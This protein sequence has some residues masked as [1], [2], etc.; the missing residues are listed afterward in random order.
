VKQF[1]RHAVAGQ[2]L[3]EASP[4]DSW[5][6]WLCGPA[7]RTTAARNVSRGTIGRDGR[8]GWPGTARSRAG[9][10]RGTAN[11]AVW[12]GTKDHIR[13][14]MFHVKQSFG[15]DHGLRRTAGAQACQDRGTAHLALEAIQRG[16][17]LWEYF[18]LNNGRDGR[19]GW[20]RTARSQPV[21]LVAQPTWLC[22]P[23]QKTM[24]HVKQSFGT[25]RVYE[26]PLEPG[27]PESWHIPPSLAAVQSGRSL[28]ECFT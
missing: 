8:G 14:R 4:P 24:F 20:P 16:R 15:G 11:L 27:L 26:G 9:R 6:S 17:S 25:I 18:T 3:P 22:G 7:Q 5:P 10:A 2:E 1:S 21:R 19:G 28:W 13:A 12:T 23:A